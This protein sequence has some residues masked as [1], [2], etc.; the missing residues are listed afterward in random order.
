ME[1]IRDSKSS[2]NYKWFADIKWYY[3]DVLTAFDKYGIPHACIEDFLVE[4]NAS[5]NVYDACVEAGQEIID[6]LSA[7]YKMIMRMDKVEE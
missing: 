6:S 7:S 5:A 2:V 3:C 1:N 4:M